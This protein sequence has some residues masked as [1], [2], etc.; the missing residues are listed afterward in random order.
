VAGAARVAGFEVAGDPAAVA[1][2]SDVVLVCVPPART[3]AAVLELLAADADV[4]VADVASVKAPV[5]RAVAAAG[6]VRRY[7]PAHPLAGSERTGWEAGDAALLRDAVWAVCPPEPRAALEPLCAFAAALEP[8]GP[9]LLACDAEAHD[10]ALARTSHVPHV[11]AQSLARLAEAG[12]LP[13][14][15][16]LSGGAYRDM[17]R[18]AR[19]DPAL[20]LD[21]VAS[22]RKA[23]AAGLWALL[24]DLERLA[25]AIETGDDAVL[26]EAWRAG[27]AARATVDAV[28]WTEPEWRPHRLAPG[29][30]AALIDLGRAGVLVRR[31]RLDG[32]ALEL[33]AGAA[34]P[35]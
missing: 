15:A 2:A 16:A 30:W 26:A 7:V 28:R 3:A 13:L 24:D 25:R 18:T 31:P 34:P 20:W 14:S 35:G 5:V 12:G 21:I 1:A 32:D 23:S 9:R 29:G 10:A 4:V 19:S 8:L 6:D 27:A 11:V 33:D 17:T 22:N